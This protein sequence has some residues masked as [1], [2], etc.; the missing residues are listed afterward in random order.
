MGKTRMSALDMQV[1]AHV[2]NERLKGALVANVYDV[3]TRTYLLKLAVPPRYVKESDVPQDE[4]APSTGE[5]E[6][7][8]VDA[9]G[10]NK[11]LLLIESGA[12]IHT[13]QFSRDKSVVPSG[14]ALKLRKHIRTRRLH[15]IRQ[16][17]SDRVLDLTFVASGSVVAHLIL[18]FYA[19]GNVILT[20]ENYKILSL[21]RNYESEAAGKVAVKEA[22]PVQAARQEVRTEMTASYAK[23]VADAAPDAKIQARKY[24]ATAL[25]L[26]PE[27]VD[28]ALC[29]S[30]LPLTIKMHELQQKDAADATFEALAK[31]FSKLQRLLRGEPVPDMPV[32]GHIFLSQKNGDVY[33][34]F[35]PFK[36]KQFQNN[37]CTTFSTFDAA[38]DEY[39]AKLE[40]MKDVEVRQKKEAAVIKKVDKLRAELDARLSD[41]NEQQSVNEAKAHLIELNAEDIDAVLLLLRQGLASGMDWDDLRTNVKQLQKAGHPLLQIVHELKFERNSVVLMLSEPDGL[42]DADVDVDDGGGNDDDPGDGSNAEVNGAATRSAELV[43]ISLDQGAYANAAHYHAGRK[44]AASKEQTAIKASGKAL[45][46]A[47][48]KARE[49]VR[50]V[51]ANSKGGVREIRKTYWFEKFS[52]FI[53]SENFLVIAGRDAQQNEIL[54]RRY[55]EQDDVY[56]HADIFGAASVLVKNRKI[57]GSFEPIPPLTLS[58]AGTFAMCRSSAWS[59][60]VVTSAWW[61]YANQVSKT[62]PSGEY[63]TTGSFMIRG[64]K[65]FLPPMQL[66]M[67]FGVL[68]R[69]D[70]SCAANHLNERTIRY[71]DSSARGDGAAMAKALLSATQVSED[72]DVDDDDDV[73]LSAG[74]K[75][76]TNKIGAAKAD[77]DVSFVDTVSGQ[78][79]RTEQVSAVAKKHISVKERKD[80]KKM[81]K[82]DS[83]HTPAP[84]VEGTT[85]AEEEEMASGDG[86]RATPAAASG[87]DGTSSPPSLKQQNIPRGKRS[88]VKKMKKKYAEQ[89]EEERE[90]ALQMLGAMKLKEERA[91]DEQKEKKQTVAA[92]ESRATA[93]DM[94]SQAD[95]STE[96]GSNGQRGVDVKMTFKERKAEAR[97]VKQLMQDEGIYELSP[98][99]LD[100]LSSLDLF[101][102]VP[103]QDDI[104][105]FALPVCAPY[106]ALSSY[107]Y[108]VKLLPGTLKR[109]K[110]YKQAHSVFLHAAE[111]A[112]TSAPP[113]C[114]VA[115][116]DALR[117]ISE[118]DAIMTIMSDVRVQAPGL[119]NVQQ[120]AGKKKKTQK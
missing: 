44:S 99:E 15:E 1:Q 32:E 26:G 49:E 106:S 34:N 76:R 9:E 92:G 84:G 111:K 114:S 12:R 42:Y 18:E 102:S 119:Q 25:E 58:Q 40:S 63:L 98:A 117:G 61:V 56:V 31:S 105:E 74:L 104:I 77:A 46:A 5:K 16:L 82:G 68:F 71:E 38:L 87:G 66:V 73:M 24:L 120:K 17:G 79:E 89:T 29:E 69:V 85:G 8:E 33:E 100:A 91:A 57:A 70:P 23:Q 109:G 47:E 72:F 51:N 37:A 2:L 78:P 19:G 86:S 101:T 64:R 50:R 3:N 112:L 113:S 27:L 110:A 28:H 41:L 22:Y 30:D 67:G 39:F 43:E 48:Q 96:K 54:V 53:S 35:G 75:E 108:K 90:L 20:D 52:W 81:N 55:L 13:T 95:V 93:G 14:F 45:K 36:L 107:R 103:V 4:S 11:V 94:S 83:S 118:N 115:E 65:N 62:A 80:A 10:W 88:K 21:L 97:Q 6:K 59:A 60:K 116:R 7:K